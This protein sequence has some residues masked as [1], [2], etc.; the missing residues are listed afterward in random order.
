MVGLLAA[1]AVAGYL[2]FEHLPVEAYPD[3][4]NVQAEVITLWP[5]HA[6]EEVGS[7]V[8][9]PIETQLNG[10]PKRADL[11]SISEF[12]LSVSRPSSRT[13]PTTRQPHAGQPAACPGQPAARRKRQPVAGFHR[14]QRGV[15]FHAARS[16]RVT[17]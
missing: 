5:G 11:R 12:G 4:T 6:A 3:V 2:A 8:T 9:V 14:R 15:P 13:T 1:Y 17:R 16:A 7:C 10:V